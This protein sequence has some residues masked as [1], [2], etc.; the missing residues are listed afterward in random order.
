MKRLSITLITVAIALFSTYVA[1]KLTG[2]NGIKFGWKFDR[3]LEA[4]G[5]VPRK[6]TNS[7]NENE[8]KFYYSPAQWAGIEWNGGVLDFF[9]DKLYQVGFL[10]STTN[11][12]R[13]TFNT[14]RTHLTDLYGD[15]IKIQSMDSNLMWRS[16]NG[17]IVMLEYVKDS[18]KEGATQFTTCV[19]F[20]D[21]KEVV[22]KAKKV[23]GELRE[24]LKGR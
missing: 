21:N 15:P 10:K 12:D 23:D 8:K 4:I 24:L 3:C 18:N 2:V 11:D 6:H 16:K 9:N 5:D 14:A 7:D 17:N 22:K 19:Y 20:I 13:T 1:E